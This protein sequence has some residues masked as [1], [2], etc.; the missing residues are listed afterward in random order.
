MVR[1]AG[2]ALQLQGAGHQSAQRVQ[3][4]RLADEVEGAGLQ[5]RD[6]RFHAAMG[7][8]HGHGDVGEILLDIFHQADAIAI[9]QAHIGQAQV[10]LHFGDPGPGLAQGGSA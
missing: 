1:A 8:D 6:G 2:V 10:R 4:D 9:R 5:R 7:G 3:F